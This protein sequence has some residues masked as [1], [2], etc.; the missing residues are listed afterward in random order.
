MKWELQL[1][2][3]YG[4]STALPSLLSLYSANTTRRHTSHGWGGRYQR[5]LVPPFYFWREKILLAKEE[6]SEGWLFG[7]G[8]T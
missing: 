6:M 2:L 3:L 8:G 7:F 5:L 4:S 1:R